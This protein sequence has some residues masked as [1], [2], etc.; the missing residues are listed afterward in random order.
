MDVRFQRI[1][2]T[3]DFSAL[4]AEATKYACE[5]A[6]RFGAE[7]HVLHT[8]EYRLNTTPV[9]EMGMAMSTYVSESKTAA[10]KSMA[11]VLD[12]QWSSNHKVVYKILE[13]TPKSAITDYARK[14]NCDLIIMATHGLTG[15]SHVLMGSV[16]EFVVRT[17]PCPVLTVRPKGQ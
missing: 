2:L 6:D 17:A 4:G 1:L 11:N 15:L 12:P 5:L 8:L 7:L 14:E 16:A 9:F 10:D 13:G 3:T